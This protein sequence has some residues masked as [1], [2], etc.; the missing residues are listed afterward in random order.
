MTA[1]FTMRERIS[2]GTLAQNTDKY[3]T[4]G[5]YFYFVLSNSNF[6]RNFFKPLDVKTPTSRLDLFDI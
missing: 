3:Q 5:E 6:T 2:V 1:Q 4:R